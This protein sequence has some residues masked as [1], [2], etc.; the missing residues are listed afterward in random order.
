M[1][2]QFN[3]QVRSLPP[4]EDLLIDRLWLIILREVKCWSRLVVL[5]QVLK[6]PARWPMAPAAPRLETS[7]RTSATLPGPKRGAA[8]LRPQLCRGA[9]VIDPLGTSWTF[10]YLLDL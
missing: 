5:C 4:I 8:Q 1:V 7:G 2:T 9:H 3:V 10:R 6:F